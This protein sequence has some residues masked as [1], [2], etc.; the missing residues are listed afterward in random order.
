MYIEEN[1]EEFIQHT[2]E[3]TRLDPFCWQTIAEYLS[4]V[5]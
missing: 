4:H 1:V 5:R 2:S 3:A